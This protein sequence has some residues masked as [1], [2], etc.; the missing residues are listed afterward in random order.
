MGTFGV[1]TE[2][3]PD[4]ELIPT[5]D[6]ATTL[7]S[8]LDYYR[9]ILIR[10]AEGITEAQARITLG[11]SDLT[12]IGLVRH[13]AEVE[14]RW[15]RRRFMDIECDVACTAATLHAEATATPTSTR[16]ESD[17]VDDA[18]RDLLEEIDFATVLDRRRVDGHPREGESG[19][20]S[21]TWLAADAALDPGAHDR[22][23]RA[24]LRARRPA[25]TSCRRGD[26]RLNGLGRAADN[27]C[28]VGA[29]C[30]S[31]GLGERSGCVDDA[32]AIDIAALLQHR[33]VGGRRGSLRRPRHRHHRHVLAGA[34]DAR[35]LPSGTR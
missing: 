32:V 11:P 34:D 31:S 25:P 22:G 8:F 20:E 9:S 29:S 6:E 1:V 3:A 15:F 4:P 33:G 12:L 27:V 23:V 28:W 7:W 30:W 26:G 35:G 17:T 13:M 24:S 2:L 19:V 5:A 21:D 16:A 18:L 14:R 10:K